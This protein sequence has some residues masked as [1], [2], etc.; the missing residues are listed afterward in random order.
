MEGAGSYWQVT[1]Q[2]LSIPAILQG[3]DVVLAAETGSGKTLS[4]IAPIA[5]SLLL[6]RSVLRKIDKH[7]G[8]LALVLCPNVM[9]CKQVVAVANAL[10][11]DKGRPLIKCAV[12]S[13]RS[14]PPFE[15][16]DLIV[17][18]P[19]ALLT[20]VREPGVN[21]GRQWREEGLAT[22]LAHVVVDEADLLLTGAYLKPLD[23]ILEVSK[24]L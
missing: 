21:Y 20:L 6:Q 15:T 13:S 7:D 11:D 19:L 14:L 5:T 8:P 9:L 22:S 17:S 4:Y 2:A 10:V 3:G 1:L 23:S 12:I 18:T 24:I 16:P